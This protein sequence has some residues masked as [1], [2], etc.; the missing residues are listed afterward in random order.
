MFDTAF[1]KFAEAFEKRADFVY[2]RRKV[3]APPANPAP[4]EEA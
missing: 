4:A 2:G 3:L 1:R